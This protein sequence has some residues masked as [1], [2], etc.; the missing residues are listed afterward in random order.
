MTI[1]RPVQAVINLAALHHNVER[2]KQY[3]PQSQIIAVVKANAYGH[4]AEAVAKAIAGQVAG[5]GVS[6][7]TEALSLRKAGIA[8]RILLLEGF[9]RSREL[10]IIAEQQLDVVIHNVAQIEMLAALK[11]S[12]PVRIWLKVDTGM[13]R[14][15]FMPDQI[16]QV[17]Q[18]LEA[19]PNVAKPLYWMSHFAD[20]DDI[21]K[22]TTLSQ[23]NCFHELLAKVKGAKSLAN[24][25]AI[26]AWPDSHNDFVRP[27][28]M[29]YGVSPL[30]N[31]TAADF[32]LQPVMTLSTELIAIKKIKQGD[33]V[34]YGST[35]IAPKDMLIG[36][37]AIGYGDGYPWHA[38]SG[39]PVLVN[40]QR[41]QLI[42]RVAMDMLVVDL[43]HQPTAKEGD[44]VILWGN[45]LP[46]EEVAAWANT[47]PYELFCS[48][49]R[50]V[51]VKII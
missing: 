23:I 38:K 49:S 8:Q 21:N 31:K 15:G 26:I 13:R 35:F 11:L 7:L 3:A 16:K 39:T 45:G 12:K 29:L 37:A 51:N 28:L 20:A 18:V 19:N 34:G 33:A 36:I 47:I 27:G 14:L 6:C 24:S 22:H 4:G 30:L 43:S 46:I 17:Q 48:I 9:F 10:P 2:V 42:G 44:P 32:N 50:R 40:G 5:F 1:G 41:V 25:A